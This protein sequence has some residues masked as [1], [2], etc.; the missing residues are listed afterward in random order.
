MEKFERLQKIR[1][2]G[3]VSRYHTIP[4]IR[5]QDVAAHSWGVAVVY[6]ILWPDDVGPALVACLYHDCAEFWTGDIPAPVKYHS[7][8]VKEAADKV[9][10]EFRDKYD[11]SFDLDDETKA[12][13][14]C[15]DYIELCMRCLEE[16]RM[17]N[18][19]IDKAFH[20]G[21]QLTTEYRKRLKT[22]KDGQLVFELQRAIEK[23][24]NCVTG[25]ELS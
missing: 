3:N 8:A 7:P 16:R 19:L 2:G 25:K 17:G 15:A 22:N 14:K 5:S 1:S 9:E 18:T 23:E 20:K 24:W 10:E 13:I 21:A 4:L 11:I 6:N 12:K